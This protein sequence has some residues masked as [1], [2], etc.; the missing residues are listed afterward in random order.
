MSKFVRL[1][2]DFRKINGFNYTYQKTTKME[3]MS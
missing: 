1:K 2:K 3:I